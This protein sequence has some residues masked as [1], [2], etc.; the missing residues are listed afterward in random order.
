MEKASS[1]EISITV[2]QCIRRQN[3]EDIFSISVGTQKYTD[4]F[5][6]WRNCCLWYEC[7]AVEFIVNESRDLFKRV[8]LPGMY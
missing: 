7:L 3:S 2:H 8:T 6:I 4:L 1:T 5:F